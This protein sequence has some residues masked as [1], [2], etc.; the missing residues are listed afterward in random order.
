VHTRGDGHTIQ[1]EGH[2]LHYV[3]AGYFPDAGIVTG[4][5]PAEQVVHDVKSVQTEHPRA[6]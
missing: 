6:H 4:L 3:I 5:Y 2:V 1:F